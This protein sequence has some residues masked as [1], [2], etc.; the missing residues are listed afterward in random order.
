MNILINCSNLVAGGG[1]QVAHSFINMLRNNAN[2][3]YIVM[4]K[5]LAEQI[6]INGFPS[7]VHFY[8]YTIKPTVYKAF[9][10]ND[11]FLDKICKINSIDAVFTVFGPSYWKP[12]ITHL[13]GFAK[14]KYIYKESPYI[15]GLKLNSKFRLWI[16][17]RI[18]LYNFHHYSD[19]LVTESWDVS[20]RLGKLIRGKKVH[21]VTNSY[22]QVFDNP[23]EWDTSIKIPAFNG[24]TLLTISSYYYHKNFEIIPKIIASLKAKYPSFSFRFALTIESKWIPNLTKDIA[25][26]IVFLGRVNVLQCPFLYQQSLIMFH[27]SFLECFSAAYPEAMKMEVP[28][29]ASDLSFA[30]GICGDAAYYFDP[31][32]A[33]EAGEAIYKLSNDSELRQSLITAGRERLKAF[34]TAESR[35]EKYLHILESLIELNSKE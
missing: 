5:P 2:E 27:P 16:K 33:V 3:L 8:N 1:I 12:K 20:E 35:A 7:T 13:V 22:N 9:T 26:H 24:I 21:T 32:S 23:D 11:V 29:L 18:D 28:I 31:T 25:D 17:E 34:D 4:S 19:A 15:V 10:G 6:D 30:R 14:P